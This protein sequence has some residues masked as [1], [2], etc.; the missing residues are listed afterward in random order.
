M[1]HLPLRALAFGAA[2]LAASAGPS[3][4]R[5]ELAGARSSPQTL[6]V[7][8]QREHSLSKIDLGDQRVLGTASLGVNGHE[9]VVSPDERFAFVPIYGNSGLNRPGSDGS[10]IDVVDIRTMQRV[11]TI[12]LGQAVRPHSI[13]FGPDGLLWVTAELAN[14]VLVV[15]P[16][17][18]RVVGRVPTGHPQSHMLAFS[19]NGRRAYTANFGTGT[20]SVIDTRKRR[21]LGTIAVAK[22]LQRVTVAPDGTVF[23]HDVDNPR[24]AIIDPEKKLVSGWIQLPGKSYASAV[25]PDGRYLVAASPE[26]D[27]SIKGRGALYVVDLKSKRVVHE[28]DVMGAPSGVTLSKE[29]SKA[30]VP[31]PSA[32]KIVVLN[33]RSMALERDVVLGPGVDGLAPLRSN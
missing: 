13:H 26:G 30:F 14:A 17:T 33:L 7:V 19:P 5:S 10:T 23:T 27:E 24:I 32:G 28:L 11:A 22:R 4:A 9:I 25:T 3:N 8:N 29:G 21:L 6:L 2:L 31:C 18:R 20:L 15:D 1:P 16:R 12:D